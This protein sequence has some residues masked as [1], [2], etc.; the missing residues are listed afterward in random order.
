MNK[1]IKQPLV[2]III[3]NYNGSKYLANCLGSVLESFYDSFEIIF[4]DNASTDDSISI[5]NKIFKD[6]K[7]I[8]VRNSSNLGF[9]EGNNIGAGYARGEYLVFLNNDTKV[10][11]TWLQALVQVMELDQK[12]GAAQS[13]MLLLDDPGRIFDSAGD[14]IDFYCMAFRRADGEKDLGQHDNMEEVFSARGACMIIR[15]S[16]LNAV[17]GFDPDF[18]LGYEDIDICWRIR[19]RGY[20]VMY[21]PKSIVFHKGYG[22]SSYLRKVRRDPVPLL[23]IKNYDAFNLLLYLLPHLA[24]SLGAFI[25]DILVRRKLV[26]ALERLDGTRWV[27]LNLRR[28]LAKRYRVQ[29]II[30]RVPDREVK[31]MMLQSNLTLYTRYLL[32]AHR[33]MYDPVSLKNLHNSYFSITNPSRYKINR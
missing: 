7:I 4:V 8:I 14:F 11:P 29:Q 31:K 5:V 22:T 3:L 25:L 30:R 16:V 9:A 23:M 28:I 33:F 13:K 27:L 32:D 6:D 1:R 24:S 17:E 26:L 19:L 2:S 15:R 21:V 20:K 12:I 18:P 10:E